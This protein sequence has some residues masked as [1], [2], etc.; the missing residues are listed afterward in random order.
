MKKVR[1][2]T[3]STCPW[4]RK[5]KQYFTKNK[6]PFENIDYDLA[7]EE[8]QEA[9]MDQ[10]DEYG[11]TGEFPFAIIGKDSVCGFDPDEY[12]RLLGKHT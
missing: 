9:I 5:A 3:L 6:I 4:C 8:E 12:A 10:M 11:G 2:Y 1:L 7:T